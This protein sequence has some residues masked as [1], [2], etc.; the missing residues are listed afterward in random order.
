[1]T[2]LE[3]VGEPLTGTET[4]PETG[5]DDCSAD[6]DAPGDKGPTVTFPGTVG[7]APGGAGLTEALPETAPGGGGGKPACG[8]GCRHKRYQLQQRKINDLSVG[9]YAV[10]YGL[11]LH[12]RPAV[13][14]ICTQDAV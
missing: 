7:D 6:G 12:S 5:P 3:T 4:F 1:M 13:A 10:G 8:G 2:L 9:C 11:Q 14:L